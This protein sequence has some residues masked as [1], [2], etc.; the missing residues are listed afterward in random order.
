MLIDRTIRGILAEL[1]PAVAR[2]LAL[3]SIEHRPRPSSADL[4]RGADDSHRAYFFGH[5]VD[6]TDEAVTEL[7]DE[8]PPR[9]VIVLFTDRLRPLTVKGL[10]VVLMHEI[11]HVLGYD[12]DVIVDELGLA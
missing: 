12:H 1:P 3:V 2:K 6:R 8:E 9:G 4:A 7:P 11:A 5:Q 10:A